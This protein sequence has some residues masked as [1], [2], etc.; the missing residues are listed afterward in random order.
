[1]RE[2]ERLRIPIIGLVDT[3]VDPDPVTYPIPGNDDAIRSCNLVIRA[4]AEAVNTGRQKVSAQEL[5]QQQQA[6]ALA[7]QEAAAAAESAPEG[8]AEQAA[9]TATPEPPGDEAPADETP[10][11]AAAE[12]TDAPAAAPAD[13]T[14]GEEAYM[15][16]EISAQLVRELREKTG[17][18]MMDCKRALQ[19]TN[20]DLEAAVVLLREKGMANAAKRA[21]RATTEGLVGYRLADDN[22]RGTMVAVGCETEP[23]SK[24]EEFQ[25]FGKK[26]LDL[27]EAGG[28]D[29][30]SQLDQE[31]AELSGKL[32]ENI[33]IAGAARFEA[34]DG[35]RLAAYVHPP[36]NK[37]GVLLHVRGG[38]DELARNLAMHISWSDPR[39]IG[40]EDVPDDLVAAERE[41]YLNSDEVQSKPEQAREKIVTGMLD[42]RFFAERGGVLAD[43]PWIHDGSLTVG[44]V[45]ADAGAAVLE[46][47]RFSLAG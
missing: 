43:Q 13:A 20:G 42:K 3:N 22:S 27:V 41:I 24:N 46:F 31:R 21:D 1:V 25:A 34:V 29:A 7:A 18:G 36:A 33:A 37:L 47:Q 4:L 35:G 10:A 45:L 28:I 2:A 39:W 32:G 12:V 14:S 38:D 15:A 30:I 44:K 26:A 6:Q 19:D 5:Q 17:G 23:V 11:D 16:A 40:R 8:E 9:P